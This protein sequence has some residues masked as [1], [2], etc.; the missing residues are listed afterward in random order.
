MIESNQTL[1]L[2]IARYRFI[3][4][5][6]TP[7][8]LPDFAA[9]TLRGAFG[10]ALKSLVCLFGNR[11]CSGCTLVQR[12]AYPAIFEVQAAPVSSDRMPQGVKRLAPYSIEIPHIPGG[13]RL[14]PGD[15]L[16]FD[17]V[18]TGREVLKELPLII[19]AWQRALA[20]GLG[21]EMGKCRLERV[22]YLADSQASRGI[23]VYSEAGQTVVAHSA[24]LC[25]PAFSST[26]NVNLHFLSPLR[27]V[28]RGQLITLA[29]LT[30]GVFLRHLIRRV[31][32]QLGHELAD[33]NGNQQVS[34]LNAQAD[35]VNGETPAMTWQDWSRYS[36]RQQQRMT[37][38]GLLGH[39]LLSD[40]PVELQKILYLGQWVHVGKETAFGLGHYQWLD[41]AG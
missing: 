27:L 3:A 21:K 31:N 23:P 16:E 2:P 35:A 41:S 37:F 38:G 26:R 10:L 36:T 24:E 6:Q 20:G 11:A 4:Q 25:L 17:M 18:L 28:Q 22:D 29:D 7:L 40:V 33:W 8:N 9:A 34:L 39:W 14:A 19:A 12:C 30:P 32:F 15:R 1:Q 13:R 5:V